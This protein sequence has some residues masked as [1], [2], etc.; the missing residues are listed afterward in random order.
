MKNELEAIVL[1]LIND[2]VS[3]IPTTQLKINV[4]INVEAWKRAP[5][6]F[7]NIFLTKAIEALNAVLSR[8]VVSIF[9]TIVFFYCYIL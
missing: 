7:R 9:F 2:R 8:K 6:S 3:V 4:F 1:E 5:D